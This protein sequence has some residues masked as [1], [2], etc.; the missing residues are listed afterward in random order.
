MN[1]SIETEK[2]FFEYPRQKGF[3][4]IEVMVTVFVMA[5]GIMGVV[6]MQS[7]GVTESNNLYFRTVAD[8]HLND[9]ADRMKANRKEALLGYGYSNL[10]TN[11]I[12][13]GNNCNSSICTTEQMASHDAL[14][15]TESIENSNL[16]NGEGFVRLIDRYSNTFGDTITA[17]YEVSIYWSE[18]RGSSG[19]GAGAECINGVSGNKSCFVLTVQI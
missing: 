9:I 16:P 8:F 17:E 1:L 6:G 2:I 7:V 15:W 4:L 5:I 18:E 12:G 11:S 3:S 13:G 19:G 14:Q 10:D